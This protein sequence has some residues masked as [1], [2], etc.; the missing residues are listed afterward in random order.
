MNNNLTSHTS[1]SHLSLPRTGYMESLLNS[2]VT[3]HLMEES[4]ILKLQAAIVDQLGVCIKG[5]T[6]EES[7]SVSLETAGELSAGLAFTLNEYLYSLSDHDKAL[8][9]LRSR[10]LNEIWLDGIRLTKSKCARAMYLFRVASASKC[11]IP[12]KSYN[13]ALDDSIR[14]C[15]IHYDHSYRPQLSCR[16][17]DYPTALD[18]K[19]EGRGIDFIVNYLSALICENHF[20]N[21]FSRSLLIQFYDKCCENE[22]F[23]F[24]TP[25]LLNALFIRFLRH[26]EKQLL[27]R[28]TDIELAEELLASLEDEEIA[29]TLLLACDSICEDDIDYRRRV[30]DEQMTRIINAVRNHSLGNLLVTD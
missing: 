28:A 12:S 30:L 17:F 2:A 26:E 3:Y 10:S 7:S 18:A 9:M 15:I 19:L 1:L 22:P 25:V 29:R 13:R 20:C 24:Y 5:F 16:S 8:N 23:N 21:K 14:D 27:L 11:V 6:K 4:D